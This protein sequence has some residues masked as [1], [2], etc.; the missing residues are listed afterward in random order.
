MLDRIS[1]LDKVTEIF[2]LLIYLNITT[3]QRKPTTETLELRV[4]NYSFKV[5]KEDTTSEVTLYQGIF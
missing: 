5:K 2:W 3:Q 1:F 4:K